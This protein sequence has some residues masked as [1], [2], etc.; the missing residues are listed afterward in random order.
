MIPLIIIGLFL[1][2][3]IIQ[4][5]DMKFL[6]FIIDTNN[7]II[8]ISTSVLVSFMV[9]GFVE[10]KT[11]IFDI[12]MKVIE[13]R[14]KVRILFLN[15]KNIN[16][17]LDRI[18]YELEK[19]VFGFRYY[20]VTSEFDSIVSIMLESIESTNE[21]TKNIIDRILTLMEFNENS[22]NMKCWL[23]N[24]KKNVKKYKKLGDYKK[25][26]LYFEDKYG[27]LNFKE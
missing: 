26:S 20:C 14:D 22:M 16:I 12:K 25:L 18:F 19:I 10:Y 11:L 24:I 15:S 27:K 3:Y 1:L 2:T 9:W 4:I 23:C 5:I 7:S 17:E 6:V 13:E 21:I 8:T